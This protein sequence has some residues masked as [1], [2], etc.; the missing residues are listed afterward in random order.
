MCAERG[1]AMSEN[2]K[3]LVR[4]Y[5]SECIAKNDISRME[6]F[7]VADYLLHIPP[8]G[9]LNLEAYKQFQ[10]TV[11][12]AFPDGRWK[13]ED[14]VAEGDKVA[15]RFSFDGTHLGEFTGLSATQ[16]KLH[17][18]GLVISRIRDGKIAE[19]WEIY[20]GLGMMQQL[21]QK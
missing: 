17:L 1:I 4:R 8:S 7:L 18:N 14:M 6:E 5:V 11:L 9:D 10:P 3:A 16:N 2:N 21:G 13:I 12:A 15:W 19:E 20:D